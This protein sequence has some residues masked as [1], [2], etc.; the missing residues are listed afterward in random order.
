M[1]G[2]KD[3]EVELEFD[4]LEERMSLTVSYISI[5]DLVSF[6]ITSDYGSV[7][8]QKAHTDKQDWHHLGIS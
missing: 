3:K 4:C 8:F 5:M 2:A 7:L 1:V 6:W